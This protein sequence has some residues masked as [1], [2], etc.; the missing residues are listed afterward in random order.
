M[1]DRSA[2]ELDCA[3]RFAFTKDCRRNSRCPGSANEPADGV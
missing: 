2:T 3:S 1:T